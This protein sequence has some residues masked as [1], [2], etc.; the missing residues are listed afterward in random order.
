[1]GARAR[2]W[3]GILLALT[4]LLAMHGITAS[5]ASAASPCG[6]VPGVAATGEH[7][8]HATTAVSAPITPDAPDAMS[9]ASLGGDLAGHSGLLCLVILLGVLLLGLTSRDWPWHMRAHL[10][11]SPQ[12]AD[13]R[14]RHPPPDLCV[15][16]VSRT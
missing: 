11:L 3:A 14:G 2:H 16:C 8:H 4:A 10:A 12:P 7:A 9:S 13:H 15:L 5:T 6:Q 1:M